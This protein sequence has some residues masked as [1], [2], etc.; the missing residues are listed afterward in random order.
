MAEFLS[1]EW[2]EELDGAVAAASFPGPDG[3]LTIEQRVLDTPGTEGEVRYHLVIEPSGARVSPGTAESPDVTVTTDYE[4]AR[5]LHEGRTTAQHALIAGR[6][7]VQGRL[8][9]LRI[10]DELSD[11]FAAVRERT[12]FPE[13]SRLRSDHDPDR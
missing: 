1:P 4:T 3:T 2:L 9:A 5:A 12:T 7:K 10:L 6:Y 11:V 13:A 8:T